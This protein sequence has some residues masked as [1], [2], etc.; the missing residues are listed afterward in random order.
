MVRRLEGSGLRIL[1]FGVQGLGFRYIDC[2]PSFL[3]FCTVLEYSVWSLNPK[4]GEMG[5]FLD[6]GPFVGN[7]KNHPRERKI[8]THS[9]HPK[10]SKKHPRFRA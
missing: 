9:E 8:L 1:G 2:D 3:G 5:R 7:Q 10:N 6:E 4:H